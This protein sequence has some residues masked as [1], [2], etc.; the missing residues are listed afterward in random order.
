MQ[1][2]REFN[3]ESEILQQYQRLRG[4]PKRQKLS[5]FL[6]NKELIEAEEKL[7]S[8]QS[9]FEKPLDAVT[10]IIDYSHFVSKIVNSIRTNFSNIKSQVQSL[11]YDLKQAAIE[12]QYYIYLLLLFFDAYFDTFCNVTAHFMWKIFLTN[13]NQLTLPINARFEEILTNGK[14]IVNEFV[15]PEEL[16]RLNEKIDVNDNETKSTLLFYY[17]SNYSNTLNNPNYKF[18]LDP[19]FNMSSLFDCGNLIST[20]TLPYGKSNVKFFNSLIENSKQEVD[21]LLTV[22]ANQNEFLFYVL[23]TAKL[24]LNDI[25]L[26]YLDVYISLGVIDYIKSSQEDYIPVL[27][28]FDQSN[29]GEKMKTCITNTFNTIKRQEPEIFNLLNNMTKEN[30]N[31]LMD[32]VLDLYTQRDFSLK[33]VCLYIVILNQMYAHTKSTENTNLLDFIILN[34]PFNVLVFSN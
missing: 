4:L 8:I 20:D 24:S 21:F 26:N 16:L 14:L 22:Y 28:H 23:N 13:K 18:I 29:Y 1:R 10:E 2:K 19:P 3:D 30:Y 33:D 12:E 17:A 6:T 34:L 9:L 27:K 31:K 11:Y 15:S 25:P 5:N 7:I 32:I